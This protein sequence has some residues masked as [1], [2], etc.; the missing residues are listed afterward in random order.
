LPKVTARKGWLIK[1]IGLLRRE[2]IIDA[3]RG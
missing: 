2:E 3:L 1:R